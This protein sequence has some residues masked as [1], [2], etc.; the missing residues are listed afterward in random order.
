MQPK[1]FHQLIFSMKRISYE[2]G[3]IIIKAYETANQIIFVEQ[4]S[5]EVFFKVDGLHDFVGGAVS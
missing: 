5:V 2:R 1:C 3:D 4:G